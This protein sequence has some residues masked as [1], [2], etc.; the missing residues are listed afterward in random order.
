MVASRPRTPAHRLAGSRLP[1]RG[2]DRW[3]GLGQD[4]R[5]TTAS[6]SAVSS[7]GPEDS[8]SGLADVYAGIEHG[9]MPPPDGS[10]RVVAEPSPGSGVVAAFTAHTVVAAD[11][12][13][14]WVHAQV[15]AG[16]LSAPLNPPFLSELCARLDRR[17]NAIDMVTLAPP[18]TGDPPLPLI[19][20]TDNDHPRVRRA[21]RY[22]QDVRV[23]TVPG[24]VLVVG[25]GVAGRFEAAF[26]VAPDARGRGLGR[27]LAISARHLVPPGR[28]VWAQVSPG[29]AASVRAL[30]AAGYQPVG[31]EALL[32]AARPLD[33]AGE[34]L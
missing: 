18:A 14:A 29:N 3:P 19:P 31:S 32:V 16:D 26:E 24:G 6:Q 2:G 13:P 5:V 10:L 23:W 12:P 33:P 34:V 21:R 22:R 27:A 17:V 4:V 25:R 8:A 15:P 7:A 11:V 9:R 20:V 30:L 1:R 28:G